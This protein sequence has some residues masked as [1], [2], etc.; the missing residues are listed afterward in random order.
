MT[1]TA[2]RRTAALERAQRALDRAR[3]AVAAHEPGWDPWRVAEAQARY[4][5][6]LQAALDGEPDAPFG[7]DGPRALRGRAGGS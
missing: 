7:Y 1:G 5:V 2:P 4:D 6:A 3:E